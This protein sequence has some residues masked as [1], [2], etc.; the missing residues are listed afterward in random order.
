MRS[1][2][3]EYLAKKNGKVGAKLRTKE[4]GRIYTAFKKTGKRAFSDRLLELWLVFGHL[5]RDVWK[6][7]E[8]NVS[9]SAGPMG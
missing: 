8:K 1:L 6:K 2:S 3:I 7:S 9:V 5:F 4:N